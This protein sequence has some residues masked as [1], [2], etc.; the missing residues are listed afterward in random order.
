MSNNSSQ[1]VAEFRNVH[2]ILCSH[3]V[4]IVLSLL[5]ELFE[6]SNE[7]ENIFYMWQFWNCERSTNKTRHCNWTI[8]YTWNVCLVHILSSRPMEV[9][10]LNFV[11]KL[12]LYTI[13]DDIQNS[14]NVKIIHIVNCVVLSFLDRCWWKGRKLL[15][16]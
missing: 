12:K 8:K 15:L 3:N 14:A 10:C 5:W 1:T 9:R 16:M 13:C 4:Y 2:C 7:F 6:L 11:Q